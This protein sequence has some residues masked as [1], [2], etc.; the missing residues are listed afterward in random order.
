MRQDEQGEWMDEPKRM[1]LSPN[2]QV[3][4]LRSSEDIHTFKISDRDED[5]S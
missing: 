3:R 4:I 2:L 1:T 5:H